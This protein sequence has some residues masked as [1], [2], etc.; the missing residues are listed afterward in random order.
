MSGP[1]KKIQTI[2]STKNRDPTIVTRK[3]G[4][5]LVSAFLLVVS[6][7]AAPPAV[8]EPVAETG[9]TS[10]GE[11]FVR[12][13]VPAEEIKL[14][15]KYPARKNSSLVPQELPSTKQLMG[16]TR[17]RLA[18]IL[19]PPGFKRRDLSVEVWQYRDDICILDI[20][21]YRGKDSESFRVKHIEAR[22]RSVVKTTL[23]DCYLGLIQKHSKE[24][25]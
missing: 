25:G 12:P 23:K 22:D 13:A 10:R 5:G 20:F 19:G 17:P 9:K 21:L 7:C 6:A 3:Y 2:Q 8:P 18:D 4:K 11:R 14:P 1:K 15:H 16:L 24:N